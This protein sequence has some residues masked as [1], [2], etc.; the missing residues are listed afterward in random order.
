M[1]KSILLLAIAATTIFTSCSNDDSNNI[2]P[3]VPTNTFT[4]DPTNFKGDINSGTVTLDASQTYNL[5]GALIVNNGAKLV[6]P[7]GTIIEA[8]G[9]TSSY[10][11][12][13]QGAKIDILG[14]A[15]E[16][17]VMTSAVQVQQLV[18]GV[19]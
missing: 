5:T 8:S 3:P 2:V 13:A 7:A 6:I 11:A 19:V 12:V 14:S 17:L 4:V 1:K 15:T 16:P 10:I 9:G 18:I